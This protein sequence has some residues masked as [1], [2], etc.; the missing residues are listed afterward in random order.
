[1]VHLA[2]NWKMLNG[3]IHLVVLLHIQPRK[4]KKTTG[5]TETKVAQTQFAITI[6]LGYSY[7]MKF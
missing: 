5:A 2:Q 1:M 6:F 3:H 7:F 4:K